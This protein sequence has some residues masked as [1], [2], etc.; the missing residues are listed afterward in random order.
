[1]TINPRRSSRRYRTLR[2]SLGAEQH[3]DRT[4]MHPQLPRDRLNTDSLSMKCLHLLV[5]GSPPFV[6]KF[7]LGRALGVWDVSSWLLSGACRTVDSAHCLAQARVLGVEESLDR[8]CHIRTQVP[9]VGD[10]N[11]RRS[12]LPRTV[13]ICAGAITAN[14]LH[15][16]IL[17][18]PGRQRRR[19]PVRKEIN[20]RAPLKVHQNRA[21]TLPFVLRPVIDSDDFGI[22]GR[23]QLNLADPLY[24]RVG[25]D[26]HPQCDG[27]ARSSLAA[28]GKTD[29]PQRL[30]QTE[31]SAC[32]RRDEGRDTFAENPSRAFHVTAIKTPRMDFHPDGDSQPWQISESTDIPAVQVSG[33]R[34]TLRTKSLLRL[35]LHDNRNQTRFGGDVFQ[36]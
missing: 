19:F 20:R 22:L 18:E 24:D 36:M 4:P 31:R 21:V 25:A 27:Q 8:I 34:M 30:V 28:Y 2:A 7:D 26:A 16:R 14:E 15:S 29:Q 12:A 1:M 6:P 10:L 33:R 35:G 5:P 17:L 11:C 9:T 3:P 32:V 23:W 13:S